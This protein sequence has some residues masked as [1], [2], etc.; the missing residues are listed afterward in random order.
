MTPPPP[1]PT[2]DITM[3]FNSEII[4]MFIIQEV[5]WKQYVYELHF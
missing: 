5:F 4:N 3:N 2:H 1:S